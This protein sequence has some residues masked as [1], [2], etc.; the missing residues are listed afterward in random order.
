MNKMFV[1]RNISFKVLLYF[2]YLFKW[3]GNKINKE[4]VNTKQPLEKIVDF[5]IFLWEKVILY[6]FES[7]QTRII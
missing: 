7:F 6:C 1:Y 3:L 2:I 5:E 4:K